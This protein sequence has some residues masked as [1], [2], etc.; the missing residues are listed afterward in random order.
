MYR[1]HVELDRSLVPTSFTLAGGASSEPPIPSWL[2][3]WWD[4]AKAEN[5]ARRVPNC[6][7]RHPADKPLRKLTFFPL[8]PSAPPLLCTLYSES[9]DPPV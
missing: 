1:A 2:W 3:G 7:L 8:S 9:E 6:K 5:V 4:V